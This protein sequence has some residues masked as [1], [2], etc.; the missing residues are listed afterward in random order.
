MSN[1]IENP[2]SKM[3]MKTIVNFDEIRNFISKIKGVS[4]SLITNLPIE[5]EKIGKWI[6]TNQLFYFETE[7][8][9]FLLRKSFDY[10]HLYYIA[11]SEDALYNDLKKF[12]KKFSS[13]IVIDIFGTIHHLEKITNKLKH[14]GF[15]IEC[16]LFR[17]SKINLSALSVNSSI[18]NV[19]YEQYTE[20]IIFLLKNN[21]DN[22]IDQ[23][24]N[25]S[26]ISN[27]IKSGNA[28]LSIS[29]DKSLKGFLLYNK[30]NKTA[31]L[32]YWFVLPKYR[33]LGVGTKLMKDFLGL[34]KDT[35]RLI[36]WVAEHNTNAIKIY[37]HYGFV[38]E[39]IHNFVLIM[40]EK[41]GK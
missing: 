17:M 9:T 35:R 1:Y 14:I 36:L 16:K 10:Y 4:N 29:E 41:N 32:R 38:P 20:D 31:I 39:K 7:R 28:L 3:Q 5:N 23:I 25:K 11:R 37:E 12:T 18:Q 13:K 22:I 30:K 24:P 33:N 15:C 6:A 34:N 19:S 27:L 8:S 26:E 40:K 21:F 2:N